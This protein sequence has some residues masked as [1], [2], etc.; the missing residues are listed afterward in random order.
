MMMEERNILFKWGGKVMV[1]TINL[2]DVLGF[3]FVFCCV[4]FILW[5]ARRQ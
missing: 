1:I 3:D 5:G 4:G 2:F